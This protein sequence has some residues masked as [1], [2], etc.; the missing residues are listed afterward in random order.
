MKPLIREPGLVIVFI[1][2]II[3][4]HVITFHLGDLLNG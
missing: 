4:F 1:K 2:Q 3:Y